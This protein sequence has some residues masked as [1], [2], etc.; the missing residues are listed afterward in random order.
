MIIIGEDGEI[1]INGQKISELTKGSKTTTKTTR[2]TVV[3]KDGEVVQN[4]FSEGDEL[5]DAQAFQNLFASSM[6][7]SFNAVQK[8]TKV[9]C[10]YCGSAYKSSNMK[11][12]N[13]GANNNSI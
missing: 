11:C 4:D 6:G 7:Q 8:E 10:E 1:T 12:P 3:I 13:C 5:F 2:K 9:K